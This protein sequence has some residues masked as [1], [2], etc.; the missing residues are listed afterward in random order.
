MGTPDD[1]S[2][3]ADEKTVGRTGARFPSPRHRDHHQPPVRRSER[4]FATYENSPADED[5]EE[6]P[7]EQHRLRVR[8]YV[9]TRGRTQG[10]H[11]LAIETL[12]STDPQAPW[13]NERFGGEYQA[14]RRLCMQPRSVAEVAALLSV[15]LGVARVLISDLAEGGFVQVHRSSMTESG[16]P[17]PVLLQR[18]LAGLYQL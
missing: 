13:T 4:V 16:R 18:V 9:L 11:Y 14:V 8:P 5:G 12:I 7:H 10:S 6:E 15:P 2:N 17:D 3:T 1:E